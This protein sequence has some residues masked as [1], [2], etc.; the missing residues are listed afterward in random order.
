[1]KRTFM[2]LAA[3]CLLALA[4]AVNAQSQ[5]SN[6]VYIHFAGAPAG[7]CSKEQVAMNDLTSDVY[8]CGPSGWTRISGPSSQ[9]VNP[10]QAFSDAFN[11]PDQTGLGT[12]ATG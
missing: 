10:S 6:I 2:A 11:R 1:M 9:L 12:S 8:A 7:S 4:P 3:L 5:T